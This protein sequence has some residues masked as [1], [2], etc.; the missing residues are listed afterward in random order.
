[1]VLA[2]KNQNKLAAFDLYQLA[3]QGIGKLAL[4]PDTNQRDL[5][6]AKRVLDKRWSEL[7]KIRS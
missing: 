3:R 6:K 1:M 4:N 2:Q 5:L 7:S